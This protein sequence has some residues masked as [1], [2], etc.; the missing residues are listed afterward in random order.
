[1]SPQAGWVMTGPNWYGLSSTGYPAGGLSAGSGQFEW[2]SPQPAAPY[3]AP[4]QF[5]A[6]LPTLLGPL[7]FAASFPRDAATGAALPNASDP[8]LAGSRFDPF[9]FVIPPGR[10][11]RTSGRPGATYVPKTGSVIA[12]PSGSV[13]RPIY[14][15]TAE[16]GFESNPTGYGEW[17]PGHLGIPQWVWHEGM[18]DPYVYTTRWFSETKAKMGLPL[19]PGLTYSRAWMDQRSDEIVTEKVPQATRDYIYQRYGELPSEAIIGLLLDPDS[20]FG[21][22]W[23]AV[24]SVPVPKNYP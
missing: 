12:P 4:P 5:G 13:G 23:G 6:V 8:I 7:P 22:G 18:K 24:I 15:T 2:R 14:R 9:G 11:F 1:M 20:P 19:L 10:R 16:P 17:V 3:S 21:T